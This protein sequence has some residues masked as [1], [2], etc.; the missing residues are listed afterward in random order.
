M[1]TDKK[2]PE[3]EKDAQGYRIITEKYACQLCEYN[4]GYLYPHLNKNCYLHF[5]GFHKIEGLDKFINLRVLY[6]EGNRIEKIENLSKLSSLACLYL[7]N[8]YITKIENLEQNTN[9]V[10]LNLSGNKIKV[11]EN[12]S[13][14]PKLENF[15]IEKNEIKTADDIKD[16]VGCKSL[17]LLDIQSNQIDEKG[18][19]I[20][21]MLSKAPQLRVLYFKGNDVIRS[22]VNYRRQMIVKLTHLTYLDD[23]PVREED[24][25]GAKAY[26]QGG[27]E[28]EAKARQE[29]K[30]LKE[31][32]DPEKKRK[33]EENRENYEERRKKALENLKN[34][35]ERRK[36]ELEEKKKELMKEYENN[37]EKRDH[38]NVQLSSV[39][40]QLE[41]NEKF[42][43]EEEENV[44]LK[45]NNLENREKDALFVYEDWMD[46]I[47]ENEVLDNFFD[48]SRALKL[49]QMEFK[50]KNVKNYELFT[51]L[52]LR[53]KWTEF[54][55]KKYRTDKDDNIY[56]YRK[57]DLFPEDNVEEPKK[58]MNQEDK[59]KKVI[60]NNKEEGKGTIINI[61]EG[62]IDEKELNNKKEN[63][64]GE[65]EEIIDTCKPSKNVTE[66]LQSLD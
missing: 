45:L 35:Y 50:K 39:D 57:E 41:E 32:I 66:D 26:L 8:N 16:I 59:D 24:R 52:D 12:I 28:A 53:T 22:I 38:L 55:L 31:G 49:I 17:T 46:E 18:E 43:Y 3:P 25:V 64:L 6:L 23:R 48:F 34:E 56:H 42:K 65:G 15:Y 47:I 40:F 54:E 9:I 27:Y 4:G 1:K 37:P 20:I 44:A 36:N 58:E 33:R 14:L 7:Q 51:V 11:I 21:D 5:S 29:Y 10:I 30:N 63:N 60:S 19:E 2:R 61:Q 13:C 62:T